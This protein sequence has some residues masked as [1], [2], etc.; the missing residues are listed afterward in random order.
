MENSISSLDNL[1][2]LASLKNLQ[3]L[4]F[5]GNPVATEHNYRPVLFDR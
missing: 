3:E 5:T 4:D 1:K 2:K